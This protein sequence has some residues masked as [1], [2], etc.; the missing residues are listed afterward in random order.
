MINIQQARRT[1]PTPTTSSSATAGWPSTRSTSWTRTRWAKKK[2]N[3]LYSEVWK[4]FPQAS[5]DDPAL[6]PCAM[7]PGESKGKC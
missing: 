6:L 1:R 5:T 2:Q 7:L 4:L 3:E